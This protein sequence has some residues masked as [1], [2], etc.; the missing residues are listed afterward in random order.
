MSRRFQ[1]A[2]LLLI[3]FASCASAADRPNIV[4]VLADD[5]TYHDAG[6]YGNHEVKT[7]NIDKLA[8]QG[9]RFDRCFTATAMCAPTR[10]QLYTGVFPVR[11][12]AYPN[13]SKVRSGTKSLGHHFKELGYRVALIGKKHY[14]PAP[15]FPFEY[16]GGAARKDGPAGFDEELPLAKAKAFVDRDADQPYFLIVAS[17]QPHKPW[18][19]GD[20][21]V[22][23][24][25]KLTVPA[26]LPDTPTTR[27]Q[28]AAYYAE[29]SYFDRQLGRVMKIVDDSGRAD[30]TIVVY[31]SEQGSNFTHCKWTCYET[32]LRTGF[33]VRWPANVKPGSTTDAM[34]QYVDVIP[35]LLHAAG[36]DP[37]KIDTGLPG[38]PDGGRG[39]DGRSFLPVLLG[40]A[41]AHHDHVFGV[42]TTRGIISGSAS[43]PIRSIRDTRYKYI[44]NLSHESPFKNIVNNGRGSA[45]FW[46]DWV[47]AAKTDATIARL[48]DR[49]RHRPAEEFYDLD[50]DPYEQKN[51]AGEPQHRARMDAMKTKLDA[52]MT[53]QG[54][55]GVATEMAWKPRK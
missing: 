44:R 14:G 51:L 54:D 20:A 53:Q 35:T 41:N 38:A 18:T 17:N 25:A 15:S 28:F 26:Y 50:A 30:N 46:N 13:H 16:L 29:I 34:V 37:Q 19:R 33:I 24:P 22:Y 31:S 47:E 49:Y 3:V 6:A 55:K 8:S 36:T 48:V 4:L 39:F 11:N 2:L 32:G 12:G 10:Q 9:M 7:P 1:L 45:D 43:Y 40:E 27:K 5:Q 52:W 23:D 21:S 42:H